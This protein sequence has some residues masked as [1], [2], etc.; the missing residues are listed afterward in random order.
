MKYFCKMDLV[1][2]YYQ[3]PIE[4]DSRP[5]TAFSTSSKHYQFKALSFGLAN[6]P[7]AFQKAMNVEL[8]DHPKENVTNFMD[9]IVVMNKTFDENLDRLDKVLETL[10]KCRVKVNAKKCQWFHE[11]VEF[12]GHRI[13]RSGI[14]K[15]EEF[16]TKVQNFPKPVTVQN[17][18][19]FLGLIQFQRKFI[20][21][22]AELTK[23]LDAWTSQHKRRKIIWTENMN[24]SFE[25]LKK[26][27][28]EDL[29]LA[30]PDYSQKANKLEV[31]TDASATGMGGALI[32][33]QWI[34]GQEI[35]R[36]IGY[37]SKAFNKAEK[38]YST[39]ERELTALR[40][41]VKTFKPFLYNI[42][43]VVKTDHQPLVYLYSM[44]NMDNRLARTYEDLTEFDYIIEY[45][46]GIDN[47]QADTM[48]RLYEGQENLVT[49]SQ[50]EYRI[51][52]GL[53]IKYKP[54]GGPL[55]L[56]ECLHFRLK[57]LN[58]PVLRYRLKN[59]EKVRGPQRIIPADP[60]KLRQEIIQY[61]ID[62]VDLLGVSN[63]KGFKKYLKGMQI[64]YQQPCQELLFIV[65]FL[66]KVIVNVYYGS[67]QP[68][69][70]RCQEVNRDS[71]R[72]INLQSK[73]GIHYNLLSEET[74]KLSLN[75][76]QEITATQETSLK[77][78]ESIPEF[79][80]ID[81]NI[82]Q[83]MQILW[84]DQLE[85][86]RVACNHC[87]TGALIATIVS[88]NQA[89]CALVD[90]GAQVSLV[91]RSVLNT[92]NDYEVRG[93]NIRMHGVSEGSTQAL[94]MARIKFS[95]DKDRV[96]QQEFIVLE[97]ESMPY[98]FLLG[99]D[100][101]RKNMLSVDVNKEVLLQGNRIET[102]LNYGKPKIGEDNA[103]FA[104]Q[105]ELKKLDDEEVLDDYD[106]QELQETSDEIRTLK[107]AIENQTSLDKWP[108]E[109]IHFKKFAK[110]LSLMMGII[111]YATGQEDD[112]K[113]PVPVLSLPG[114]IGITV[115]SHTNQLAHAGKHKLWHYMKRIAFHPE[116]K[117]IVTDVAITCEYC[118]KY[119]FQ[120]P[121]GKPPLKKILTEKPFELVAVDCVAL[122]RTSRGHIA[123]VV[124]VDHN[125]KFTYAAPLK[126]KT[127]NHVA[128]TIKNR[129]LPMMVSKP[130]KVLS[131]NGPEFIGKPYKDML[132]SRGIKRSTITPFMSSSNGLAERTIKTLTELARVSS[133]NGNPWDENLDS[134]LWA[135]N[136]T[137]HSAIG[138]SPREYLLHK[139]KTIDNKQFSDD[140][141]MLWRQSTEKYKSFEKGQLV[142][143]QVNEIGRKT[144]NKLSEKYK[145]PYRIK[146]KWDNNVTYL[147]ET[148]S[149][150]DNKME[151][152]AH[153]IQ[154]R[155]WHEPP[156]YLK[157]HPVYKMCKIKTEH[158]IKKQSKQQEN[159]PTVMIMG[160]KVKE[161]KQK[162]NKAVQTDEIKMTL[163]PI[164][165]QEDWGKW[166]DQQDEDH[167]GPKEIEEEFIDEELADVSAQWNS[168]TS[169]EKEQWNEPLDEGQQEVIDA[170]I[171]SQDMEELQVINLEEY[172]T[173]AKKNTSISCIAGEDLQE[174]S[175]NEIIE[176]YEKN[177]FEGFQQKI[178]E[179]SPEDPEAD[180]QQI[181]Q[182]DEE[183][184]ISSKESSRSSSGLVKSLVSWFSGGSSETS[185]QQ[186]PPRRLG[187]RSAGP[188]PDQSWI[189]NAGSLQKKGNN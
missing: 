94:E 149:D 87:F 39:I 166:N 168:C 15:S 131:D 77:V 70:F 91:K 98:C 18:K 174:E 141:K 82:I 154:L 176:N 37:A 3:M 188:V 177:T 14:K 38:R 41:C 96:Y 67:E 126:D 5:I 54:E 80:E 23:P 81:E 140:D 28:A 62:R 85:E 100:F 7:A 124:M 167:E 29:T 139:M 78:E 185:E 170:Q 33:K 113:I 147:L 135:Y 55:A 59:E 20:K 103:E 74:V 153:Q 187:L 115:I 34:D 133:A 48:S 4:I 162:R 17:L 173:R 57:Q 35:N 44:R 164:L 79:G 116:L 40:F 105:V 73:A 83:D 163:S 71:D 118:Q 110:K 19:G 101:L 142:V 61:A 49:D 92:L 53:K 159:K 127:S 128:T 145:G 119:K 114:I 42:P 11:E 117:K 9:D 183:R 46:P 84:S 63:K 8:K 102:Y 27:A 137:K 6:A 72:V 152:R 30:Y 155:L 189:L 22:C 43:F 179:T 66:Y 95:L 144:E 31:Y 184:E 58:P 47:S 143:K 107:R 161:N 12:L 123:A 129:L 52:D 16:I 24:K 2:G 175:E 120:S 112:E 32:Q 134:I 97:N 172:N 64:G 68:I 157:A 109:I 111:Y 171:E 122:P 148:I 108:L 86:D 132:K 160:R 186:I 165:P 104:G 178:I 150:E 169:I 51:P 69:I 138:T 136:S 156:A 106:I 99:I 60:D 25:A 76:H 1:K 130:L 10:G 50:T 75:D 182:K 56:F 93:I 89:R 88:E 45:T 65:S 26:K 125:S 36:V 158:E 181:E 13:T 21:N 151:V 180:N 90:A 121:V 146:E